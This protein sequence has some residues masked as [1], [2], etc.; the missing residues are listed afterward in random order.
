MWLIVNKRI[1]NILVIINVISCVWSH[2]CSRRPEGYTAYKTPADGRFQL[3]ISG[4]S[5][6]YNPGETYMSE[7]NF[8]F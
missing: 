3:K 6:K 8:T 7:Y 4:S 5:T 2:R 1:T